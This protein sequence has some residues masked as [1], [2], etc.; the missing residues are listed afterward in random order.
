LKTA[1]GAQPLQRSATLDIR[2]LLLEGLSGAYVKR[3][4]EW[5][6]ERCQ[7]A[8]RSVGLRGLDGLV[9]SFAKRSAFCIARAEAF[10]HHQF[11]FGAYRDPHLGDVDHVEL[12]T[13]LPGENA[14]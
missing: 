13:I 12:A 10:A 2:A 7:S 11:R 14:L 1:I 9:M 8:F 4:A 6:S 3:E 5:L